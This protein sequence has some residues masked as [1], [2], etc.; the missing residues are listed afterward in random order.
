VNGSYETGPPPSSCGTIVI[1]PHRH[2]SGTRAL[3]AI[4]LG[5]FAA[6]A[7]AQLD[8]SERES[9]ETAPVDQMN[10]IYTVETAPEID[11]TLED[12]WQSGTPLKG[13]FRQVNP[14]EGELPTER[15]EVYLM[16]DS[17]NFYVGFRCWDENPSGISATQ[18]KYDGDFDP[19]DNV[20]IVI[21]PFRD[22]RTG[23]IFKMTAGGARKDGRITNGDRIDFNWD[24]IWYGRVAL[25]EKGWTAEMVIPFQ[26]IL[27]DP[28]VGDW[29]INAERFIR[30]KNETIRW[31]TPRRDIRI[32]SV[33]NAD[34]MGGFMDLDI[35]SGIDL[36]PFVRADIRDDGQD[37]TDF[38]ATAGLDLFWKIDPSLTLALTINNDFAETEVDQRQINFGRFPLFFPEKRDFFLEDA[39]F[40]NFGGIRRNPLPFYSRRIGIGPEGAEQGILA[41]A[42]L[43]G[44]IED[45][46]L[47]LM[48]VQMKS[49]GFWKNYSVARVFADVLDESTVGAI[50]TAGDPADGE[51]NVVGGIDFNYKN[52][53]FGDG[54][55]LTGN[56]F[57]LMSDSSD[58][59]GD[60][61]AIGFKLGYPNDVV[62]WFAGF[63]RIGDAY[64]AALGFNPRVGIYEY[65]GGWRYRWRP[66]DGFIR[67]V[68]TGFNAFLVTDLESDVESIDFELEALEIETEDGTRIN[69]NYL[70]RREVPFGSFTVAD[71]VTIAAGDYTWN[72]YEASFRSSEGN[73]FTV[74]GDIGWSGYYGGTR[75]EWSGGAQWRISPQLV[76]GGTFEYNDIEVQDQRVITRQ[77]TAIADIY[78][79][80]DISLQNYV[81]WDDV[82]NT[83][84]I[85]SR[86][87]WSPEPGTDL[88]IVFNQ[89]V[90]SENLDFTLTKSELITK[91]GWTIRF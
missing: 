76:M 23:Y 22:R 32:S 66:D 91:F 54:T 10:L 35:G 38:A 29:G 27:A 75:F 81:Q 17:K 28:D 87:R 16:R 3:A 90:E 79:T 61:T 57:A 33:A 84:G 85:N 15:T 67:S 59:S 12:I 89:N 74:N 20:T 45:L 6:G 69:L 13:G 56:A 14:D 68:E 1:S 4:A 78:F 11:G 36:K 48:N 72:G 19:D 50:M 86:F 44:K 2:A 58:Q 30:R 40:F 41:G 80:P 21:D 53:N 39:G 46:N 63:S 9:I 52:T 49:N 31:A 34:V 7:A 73:P 8:E 82:S 77:L 37:Q 25:D 65:Y 70:R 18:M 24:G 43:T 55:T 64:D 88:F 5:C 62:G 60:S 71:A 42:R 51:S 83:V 47:G 26:T